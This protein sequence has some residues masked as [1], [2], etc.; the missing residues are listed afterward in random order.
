[1][2]DFFSFQDRE[3]CVVL[4]WSVGRQDCRSAA[5]M[6]NGTLSDQKVFAQEFKRHLAWKKC[7][8]S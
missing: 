8:E 5:K 3:E 4:D 7:V 6:E 1:M 2:F